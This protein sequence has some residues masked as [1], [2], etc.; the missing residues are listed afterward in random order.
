MKMKEA[1]RTLKD[2]LIEAGAKFRGPFPSAR[3]VTANLIV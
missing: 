2:R 1:E 3:E